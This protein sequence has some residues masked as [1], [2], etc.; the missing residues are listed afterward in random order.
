MVGLERLRIPILG[1]EI[2][3]FD[4]LKY[5]MMALWLR[6]PEKDPDFQILLRLLVL[7]LRVTMIH[8]S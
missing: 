7:F 2:S 5:N 4:I 8:G 1:S 6:K 3:D